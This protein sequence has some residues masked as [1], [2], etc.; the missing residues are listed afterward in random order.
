MPYSVQYDDYCF[1]NCIH[2]GPLK[3][4][5]LFWTIAPIFPAGHLPMDPGVHS[6]AY[7]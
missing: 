2:C 1:L 5:T 6:T 7:F 3:G 4:A